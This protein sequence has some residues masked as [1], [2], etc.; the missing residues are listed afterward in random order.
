MTTKPRSPNYPAIDL[1]TAVG[2]VVE[3][4]PKVQ[5]GQFT[6]LDAAAAW[7]YSGATNPVRRAIAALRQ[8]GLIEARKGDYATLTK[9]ALTL[10]LRE[11]ES[12]EFRES[13]RE[14]VLSPALF[15]E[16]I[17][18]GQANNATGAL[19]QLL[20]V[21]KRF[22]KDGAET[23]IGVLKASLAFAN[24]ADDDTMTW[25]DDGSTDMSK[26]AGE[27]I[28]GTTPTAAPSVPLPPEGSI[29]IPVPLSDGAVGTITVPVEMTRGDWDRLYAILKAYEPSSE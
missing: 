8:Y 27:T 15:K 19:R 18:N 13:L 28:V 2:R 7:G 14:A 17:D 9:N 5:R 1:R 29:A 12:R 11:P 20:V 24:V 6:S 25:L 16:L 22:T 23:F 4:Y 26:E 21:E 10:V 3:L